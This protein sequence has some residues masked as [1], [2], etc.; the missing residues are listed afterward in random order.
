MLALVKAGVPPRRPGPP[1]GSPAAEVA[2]DAMSFRP[3]PGLC[4]VRT[5]QID[6]AGTTAVVTGAGRGFGR[7]VAVALRAAGATV[8]GVSR[9]VSDLTEV[10]SLL[11]DGFVP[12][13]ADATDAAVATEVLERHRPRTLV[14]NAGATPWM[15]SLREQT[16]QSF[17]RNWEVDTQQA[18]HWSRTALRVPLAA[19]STVVTMSSGAALR[20][21]PLSGGYAGAKATVRFI[22]AYA[23]QESQEAGLGIRFVAV[24]PQLTPETALGQA[25]MRAYAK[26]QGVDL[27]DFVEARRPVLTPEQVGQ[28]VVRLSTSPDHP[29]PAYLLTAKGLQEVP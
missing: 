28:A 19:G 4:W 16:W 3:R 1:S 21:S 24:L 17:S 26:Q 9:S 20:G 27:A 18:F 29:D 23:G 7:A 2:G 10:G 6:L 5:S 8:V 12:V 11:G 14:L 15:G 25:G 22:T 13:E